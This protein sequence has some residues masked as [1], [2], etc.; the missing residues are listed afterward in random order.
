MHTW[1]VFLSLPLLTVLSRPLR[2]RPEVKTVLWLGLLGAD[3]GLFERSQIWPESAVCEPW[4][5][6]KH[7]RLCALTTPLC[8]PQTELC[9][10]RYVVLFWKVNLGLGLFP[11]EAYFNTAFCYFETCRGSCLTRAFG[12]DLSRIKLHI[13]HNQFLSPCEND[14]SVYK[15]TGGPHGVFGWKTM[16]AS[17][18]VF[19]ISLPDSNSHNKIDWYGMQCTHFHL[20]TPWQL[21]FVS[22]KP[23]LNIFFK[24]FYELFAVKQSSV[25]CVNLATA[26]TLG[27]RLTGQG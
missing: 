23:Q 10:Q 2:Q 12:P 5:G 3:S 27:V 19:D 6:S 17:F 21:R 25:S 1:M 18:S 14:R 22:L 11:F 8:D 4:P 16:F 9:T 26:V 13:E 20:E 15:E 24:I 7:Y